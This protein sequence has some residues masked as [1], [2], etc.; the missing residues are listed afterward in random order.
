MSR[1]ASKH[2]ILIFTLIIGLGSCN[3][4]AKHSAEKSSVKTFASRSEAGDTLLA[5]VQSG[6]RP[7]LL[8]IFG[9]G[10]DQIFFTRDPEQDAV[11][12][13]NFVDA[14]TRMN[15]WGKIKAGGQTLYIGADNYPFPIPLGQNS[16]GRWYFDTAAG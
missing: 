5:A 16:S 2:G 6:D 8:E 11:D 9:P 14:Y 4:P 10:G 7:A 3:R 13:K 12:R 15:R 1:L